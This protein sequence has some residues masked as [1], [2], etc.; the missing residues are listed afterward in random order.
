V[1]ESADTFLRVARGP[2]LREGDLLAICGTGAYG[3]SMASTYNGR[4]RPAEVLCDGDEM[5]VLR[6]RDTLADL[7]RG[8]RSLDAQAYDPTVPPFLRGNS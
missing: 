2:R 5:I 6:E 7:W 3:A 1:C 8:E 4:P